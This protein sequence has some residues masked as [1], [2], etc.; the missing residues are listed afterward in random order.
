[1]PL[2]ISGLPH[3]PLNNLRSIFAHTLNTKEEGDTLE[4]QTI[5]APTTQNRRLHNSR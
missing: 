1:M 3:R 4:E 5:P 2:P